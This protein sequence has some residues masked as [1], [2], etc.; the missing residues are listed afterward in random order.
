MR[1]IRPTSLNCIPKFHQNPLQTLR[2]NW[3]TSFW[4]LALLRPWIKVRSHRLVLK[5]RVHW[6]LSAKFK[7]HQLINIRIHP[8]VKSFMKSVS[9]VGI[10]LDSV[11]VL[12]SSIRMFNWRCFIPTSNFI[13]INWKVCENMMPRCFWPQ[14]R[15]MVENARSQWC[16]YAWQVWKNLV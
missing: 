13:F 6:Y 12:R 15:S 1:F 7:P 10:S 2:V 5:C 14:Q 3:H 8:S 11:Q 9:K 4:F 16:L